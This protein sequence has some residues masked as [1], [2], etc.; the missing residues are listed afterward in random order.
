M[1]DSSDSPRG[2][3]GANARS[4][5]V[6]EARELMSRMVSVIAES[7]E[8]TRQSRG[9]IGQSL[10]RVAW[11]QELIGDATLLDA[12]YD[13]VC[14]LAQSER[15]R[16]NSPERMLVLL[17]SVVRDAHPELLE[18]ALAQAFEADVVRWGIESYYST[19]ECR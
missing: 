18:R 1:S 9:R 5:V 7:R 16:G 6:R 13:A 17:K 12:L 8:R 3:D 19:S 14:A 11:S 4:P 15:I 2:A 10:E